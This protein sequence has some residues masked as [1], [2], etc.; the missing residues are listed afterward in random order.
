MTAT[1]TAAP[2]RTATAVRTAVPMGMS[3]AAAVTGRSRAGATA[4]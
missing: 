2:V 4:D 1:E 3:R